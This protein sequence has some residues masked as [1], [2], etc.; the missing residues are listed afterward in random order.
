MWLGLESQNKST[1]WIWLFVDIA[2]IGKKKE[3]KNHLEAV[4]QSGVRNEKE[5]NCLF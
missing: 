3:K 1:K 4:R 2:H 5:M